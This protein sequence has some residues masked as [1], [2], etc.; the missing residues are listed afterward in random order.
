MHI[1]DA[2]LRLD[3]ATKGMLDCLLG[4][5]GT[6]ETLSVALSRIDANQ[7]AQAQIV[8]V[9]THAGLTPVESIDG[10]SGAAGAQDGG[11]DQ[12][13]NEEIRTPKESHTKKDAVSGQ[14]L[15]TCEVQ[16][17]MGLEILDLTEDEVGRAFE[18]AR[19]ATAEGSRVVHDMCCCLA[20]V[21]R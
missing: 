1:R 14:K 20:E 16:R 3:Q 10:C 15:N 7:D 11:T 21:R 12:A 9:R 4:Q 18:G 2:L 13:G 5:G 6:L 19:E 17:T 8:Y